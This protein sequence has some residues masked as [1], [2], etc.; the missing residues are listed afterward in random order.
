MT[1][2]ATATGAVTGTPTATPTSTATGEPTATDQNGQMPITPTYTPTGT[3]TGMVTEMPTVTPSVTLETLVETE[4]PTY[5]PTPTEEATATYTP[6]P[7]YTPTEE[8]TPTYTPTPTEEP[9]ATYTP[10]PTATVQ[11]CPVAPPDANFNS[12]L[13]I[14]LDSTTSVTDF[15]SYP[16]GDTEDR[17]RFSVTGMNPNTVLP[18]GRARLIISVS[19]FGTGINDVQFF[20]GG[21]TYSCGQTLVDK[22]VTA[23][24]D[25]GTVTITAV[26]GQCSYV[27]WVLTGTATRVN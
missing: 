5:T 14:A 2:Q 27:Q 15:V 4:T 23:D 9:T 18:G 7:T 6:S 22:E 21:Q 19:C 13:D 25:T 3:P 20:T 26:G 17:V 24:S 1:A 11:Q 8:Y 16:D 12:P 10:T